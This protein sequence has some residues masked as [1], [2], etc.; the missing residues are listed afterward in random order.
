MRL[1]AP[2]E[3]EQ[4]L[5]RGDALRADAH[6]VGAPVPVLHD[7]QL[8][9]APV[10][11]IPHGLTGDLEGH[12]RHGAIVGR[13]PLLP[14]SPVI[15]VV[16][17]P[18]DQALHRV[19]LPAPCLSE[20]EQRRDPAPQ[21][22]L[23]SG[24]GAMCVHLV[25]LCG[26]AENVRELEAHVRNEQGSQVGLREAVVDHKLRAASDADHVEFVGAP[27]VLEQ[28][29]LPHADAHPGGV[30]RRGRGALVHVLRPPSGKLLVEDAL[31]PLPQLALV[32]HAPCG[33]ILLLGR[34]G[35]TSRRAGLLLLGA[36]RRGAPQHG[37]RVVS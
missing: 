35:D 33:A 12:Q 27:L 1:R 19:G 9:P 28:G 29:P 6:D 14:T 10:E 36:R 8:L 20:H 32:E 30:Q 31:V 26:V 5:G 34:L 17:G 23:H 25:V 4:L 13:A 11:Q 16:R 24:R 2:D 15:Q 21:D 18:P 7:L 37:V 22:M 3:F